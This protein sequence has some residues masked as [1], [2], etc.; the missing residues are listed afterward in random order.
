MAEMTDAEILKIVRDAGLDVSTELEQAG[1]MQGADVIVRK[2]G[3]L[4]TMPWSDISS[5]LDMVV[6]RADAAITEAGAAADEAQTAAETARVAAAQAL[7][8]PM[9]TTFVD[10]VSITAG[11]ASGGGSFVFDQR[12]GT[13]LFC[14]T[15]NGNSTY[16]NTANAKYGT[17]GAEGIVP[18]K[19]RI[20]VY[21]PDNENVRVYLWAGA[22][23]VPMM[24]GTGTLV[25]L[26]NLEVNNAIREAYE[27]KPLEPS[28]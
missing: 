8:A 4:K 16:Y 6:A 17:D 11:D 21:N 5:R 9:F 3:V 26:T 23:M 20:Y 27:E 22:K 1:N 18:A 19:D 24:G 12:R 13:F 2:D 7:G 10:G 14:I 28:A 15:M 25:Q